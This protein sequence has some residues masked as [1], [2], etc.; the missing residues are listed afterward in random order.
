MSSLARLFLMVL[1][2]AAVLAASPSLVS[3]QAA[4][5]LSAPKGAEREIVSKRTETSTTWR[6]KSGANVTKL[7]LG[8]V[9][10]RD[11]KGVLRPFDLTIRP[12]GGTT[13]YTAHAGA[14]RIAFPVSLAGGA[15]RLQHEGDWVEHSLEDATGATRASSRKM[16]YADAFA[17]VDVEMSATPEGLKEDLILRR[18]GTRSAFTYLITTSAGLDARLDATSGAVVFERGKRVVFTMPAATM[19]DAAHK[20]GPV[21]TMRLEQAGAGRWRLTLEASEGWLS[22]PERVWPVTIDPTSSKEPDLGPSTQCVLRDAGYSGNAVYTPACNSPNTPEAPVGV[23]F[24]RPCEYCVLSPNVWR[25]LFKVPIATSP[26]QTQDVVTKATLRMFETRGAEIAPQLR[27]NSVP[28]AW[29]ESTVSW[30]TTGGGGSEG[31]L[32][33]PFP[34]YGGSQ[35]VAAGSWLSMDLTNLVNEWQKYRSNPTTGRDPDKGFL[36][37]LGEQWEAPCYGFCYLDTA[38]W[39]ATKTHGEENKRPYMEIVAWPPAPAGTKILSPKEGELTGRRVRLQAYASSNTVSTAR[40]QY[41]SPGHSEFRDI[42]TSALRFVTEQGGGNTEVTSADI[43]V[44]AQHSAAVVWDIQNTPGGEADGNFHVRALLEDGSLAGGGVTRTVNLRLDRGNP[45]G[46]ALEPIGPGDV[47]LLTGDFQTTETDV[48][49]A[50]WLGEL[51]VSRTYHSRGASKREAE[52]FGPNWAA[53]YEADGGSMPYKGLQNFSEIKQTQV[54]S[55]IQSPVTYELEIP[56]DFGDGEEYSVPA[57]FDTDQWLPIMETLK[58]EYRYLVVELVDGGKITF[59]QTV[60]PNGQVTGWVPDD[61]HRGFSISGAQGQWVLTDVDGNKTTFEPD[62]SGST[63][64]HPTRFQTPGSSQSPTF[65]WQTVNNRLRLTKVTA[66]LMIAGH[67]ASQNRSV[68]FSWSD[69]ST[70]SGPQPR[71]IAIWFERT[72]SVSG[73]LLEEIQLAGYGYDTQGRLSYHKNKR[74]AG[75][76]PTEYGYDDQNRLTSIRPAG[77]EPWTLA[78]DS[79]TGDPNGGRLKSISRQHPTLGNATWSIRY[80]VPLSGA[81]APFSMTP[82]SAATWGQSDDLPTDA[83]A[84]FPPDQVPA[85]PPTSWTKATVHYLDVQGREVNTLE[86]GGAISTTQYD[87]NGNVQTELTAA[88]R[89]RALADPVNTVTAAQ[90]LMTI[91]TY[92]LN[93]VDEIRLLSPTHLMKLGDGSTQRARR[94]VVTNYDLSQAPQTGI[95]YHLPT[96]V[97]VSARLD[98]ASGTIRDTT[99]TEYGY[100]QPGAPTRGWD[101]RRATRVTLDPNGPKPLTTWT[102]YDTTYPLVR[103][104]RLPKSTGAGSHETTYRYFGLDS[105]PGCQHPNGLAGLLCVKVPP[106]PAPQETYSYNSDWQM[107]SRQRSSGGSNETTTWTYA[108]SRE[109]MVSVSGPGTAVPTVTTSYSPL[110]GRLTSTTTAALGSDPA[111]TIQRAYD[112]NGRLSSYTDADGAVTTYSYDLAGRLS[113]TTE[114][115]GSSTLTYNDRGLAVSKLD[116]ALGSAITAS[117]DADG[118]LTQQILPNG[119]TLANTYNEDGAVTKRTYTKSPCTSSCTWVS[120]EANLDPQGRVVGETA[121]GRSRTFRYDGGGRLDRVQDTVGTTCTTRV[122]T[123]DNNSNRLTRQKFGAGTGGVCS[124]AGA[125]SMW[126]L[127]Y[128]G[129]DRIS[130]GG[131]TYDPMGRTTSVPGGFIGYTLNS[132]YFASGSAATLT[133]NGVTVTNGL[134]PMRRVRNRQV[135][136]MGLSEIPHFRDD[137]DSPSWIGNGSTAWTRFISSLE[138]DLLASVDQAGTVTYHLSDLHGDVVAD[139]SSSTGATAPATT[140]RYDEWGTPMGGSARR[141]GWHGS[142]QR[143]QEFSSGVIAMGVR[144]YSPHLGRFLQ[145]DPIPGGSCSSYEYACGDPVNKSDLSGACVGPALAICVPVAITA[146]RAVIVTAVAG[147]AAASVYVLTRTEVREIGERLFGAGF[148]FDPFSWAK[149]G[150]QN[151]RETDFRD[152]EVKDLEKLHKDK[153]LPKDVKRKVKKELKFRKQANKQ[154]RKK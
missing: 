13:A 99:T 27:V 32:Q 39:F 55:W 8:P 80:D 63:S 79:L 35:G 120:S 42:P 101:L 123:Y 102:T 33:P 141:Y 73:A 112:S 37:R 23:V 7:S 3:A 40:W 146:G 113:T 24:T 145:I 10:W 124:E 38:W 117:Y 51:G 89:Q 47:N 103:T 68:R 16:L 70:P 30:T 104:T 46:A 59:T 140:N 69:V 95:D 126:T 107:T 132:T 25:Q 64:Y 151:H 84:V 111:R 52:M 26:I 61:D 34:I 98:D 92:A 43:Q 50:A 105:D 86:P 74:I 131:F 110:T 81:G 90:K 119:L 17:G 18:R 5:P 144:T 129:S 87:D 148:V 65:T 125:S 100:D 109:S 138:G 56:V 134:D 139:A 115:K 66:P 19:V 62:S 4:S 48:K 58:W 21:P 22:A 93:G 15:A 96:S 12:G 142:E 108:E 49:V 67:P 130:S 11:G 135:S 28:H 147:G 127:S 114:P 71:V 31:S 83:T 154:K 78:Y 128:D 54:E 153:S 94:L 44:S 75:G 82:A 121:N 57:S 88:N 1:V 143:S 137:S 14:A 36:L 150:K 149:G 133:Q 29:N 118:A 76:L 77:E 53:S 106:A 9:R 72:D 85:T 6:M 41:A 152:L 45:E 116:S 60:D 2:G 91:H 97:T 20:P 122:Y 136:T